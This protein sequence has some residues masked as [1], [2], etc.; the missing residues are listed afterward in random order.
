MY[1]VKQFVINKDGV[2]SI[3]SGLRD[4]CVNHNLA[5]ALVEENESVKFIF[6]VRGRA[7]FERA[8]ETSHFVHGEGKWYGVNWSTDIVG[9]DITIYECT[10]DTFRGMIFFL[11][12]NPKLAIWR[13]RKAFEKYLKR[14]RTI[15]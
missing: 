8:N 15:I 3:T 14:R 12:R 13:V 6:E 4:F 5:Y 1:T 2:N 10:V 11:K 7:H 9:D